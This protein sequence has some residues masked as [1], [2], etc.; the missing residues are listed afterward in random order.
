MRIAIIICSFLAACT[1][2]PD[3]IRSPFTA[4]IGG[5]GI[6]QERPADNQRRGA[7]E[8]IVKSNHGAILQDIVNGGGPVLTGAMDTAGIPDAD[9]A[10]RVL[11]MQ[12]D[13]GLYQSN[14]GALVLALM[15]YGR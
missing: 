10:A 6:A 7:V 8:V 5:P 14:P 4:P 15:V 9:R 1:S 2:N 11:Q 12:R 13:F 3:H